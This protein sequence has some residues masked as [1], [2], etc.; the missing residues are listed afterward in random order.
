MGRGTYIGEDEE[1]RGRGIFSL[2][3][4]GGHVRTSEGWE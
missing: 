2:G 3:M 4:C 1:G